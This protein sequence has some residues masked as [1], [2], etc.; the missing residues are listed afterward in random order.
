MPLYGILSLFNT[1]PQLK[2]YWYL[3]LAGLLCFGF[4]LIMIDGYQQTNQQRRRTT[5]QTPG[6]N[7]NSNITVNTGMSAVNNNHSPQD[8]SGSMTGIRYRNAPV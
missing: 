4:I 8:K 7:T 1:Y 2:Y 3:A 5:R 6:N